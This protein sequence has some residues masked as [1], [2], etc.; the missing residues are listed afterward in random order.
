MFGATIVFDGQGFLSALPDGEWNVQL[1]LDGW[2]QVVTANRRPALAVTASIKG[3]ALPGDARA[4]STDALAEIVFEGRGRGV[5]FGPGGRLGMIEGEAPMS[6]LR[7][8]ARSWLQTPLWRYTLV[9]EPTHLHDWYTDA[10]ASVG[11]RNGPAAFTVLGTARFPTGSS[12][13][14]TASAIGAWIVSPRLALEAAYGGFL[15]DPFLGFEPATS[16]SFGVRVGLGR[17]PET[18]AGPLVAR[19][20]GQQAVVRVSVDGATTVAIAGEWTEWQPVPL[21]RLKP[22]GDEW[23]GTFTLGPGTYRFNLLVDGVRWTL[24][25]RVVSVSDEL[26]GRVGLLMVPASKP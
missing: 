21:R 15:S 18:S 10:Q 25:E 22:N 11:W 20:R 7:L 6:A 4:A 17:R 8:R 24:P 13:S 14:A 2:W 23:E 5:A 3:S 19:R 1:L 9:V 16:G 26:G 12:A